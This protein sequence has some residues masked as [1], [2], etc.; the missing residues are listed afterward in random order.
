MKINEKIRFE[1]KKRELT[2]I[3]LAKKADISYGMLHRLEDGRIASPHPELL[4]K[5]A[6]ALDISYE[7]LLKISGYISEDDSEKV[8]IV[9]KEVFCFDAQYILSEFPDIKKKKAI[10]SEWVDLP[11]KDLMAITLDRDINFPFF[12]Q[13]DTIFIGLKKEIGHESWVLV[14]DKESNQLRMVMA[15][16]LDETI[17][18]KDAQN[19]N[20]YIDITKKSKFKIIGSVVGVKSN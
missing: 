11:Y 10:S 3:A 13:Q 2:L 9:L 19:L 4:K 1:R 8:D 5:V 17:T 12:K 18:Y 14:K 7:E 16:I 6:Y 20:V 15:C